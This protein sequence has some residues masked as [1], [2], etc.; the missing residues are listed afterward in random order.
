MFMAFLSR[1][2]CTLT[3]F[4]VKTIV[5]PSE[6][7]IRLLGNLPTLTELSIEGASADPLRDML[8]TSLTYNETEDSE[9]CLCPELQAITLAGDIETS[10][11]TLV[12]M[13]ESRCRSNLSNPRIARLQR[14]TVVLSEEF[15]FVWGDYLDEV[16][17]MQ[18]RG[19]DVVIV[20]SEYCKRCWL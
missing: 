9:K 7:L 18:D 6:Q 3:T 8:I 12:K 4:R 16:E 17:T 11:G 20:G 1:S 13:L 2:G 15:G 19:L 5:I 14:F 10:N